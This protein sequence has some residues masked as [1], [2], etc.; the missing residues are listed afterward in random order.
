MRDHFLALLLPVLLAPPF[1]EDFLA[2]PFFEV[3][4]LGAAALEGEA[5]PPAA[6]AAG[7][8]LMPLDLVALL[9]PFFFPPAFDTLLATFAFATH[10]H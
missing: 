5:D 3:L 2:P 9:V 4:L 1:L 6:A 7:A 8:F 10:D